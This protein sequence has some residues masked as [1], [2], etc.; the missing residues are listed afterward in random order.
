MPCFKNHQIDLNRSFH[1]DETALNQLT[2]ALAIFDPSYIEAPENA[3]LRI[4]DDDYTIVMRHQEIPPI[5]DEIIKE[6]PKKAIDDQ[7]T[8]LTLSDA[9]YEKA[10]RNSR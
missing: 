3:H 2:D 10:V 7:E 9:C 4:T 6:I 8:T 5:R 1:Y